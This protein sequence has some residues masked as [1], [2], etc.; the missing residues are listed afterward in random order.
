MDRAT[1]VLNG[2]YLL[3]VISPLFRKMLWLRVTVVLSSVFFVAYGLVAGIVSVA[4]WN[5]V[6][7]LFHL[8]HIGRLVK[9]RRAKS[10]SPKE[11]LIRDSLFRQMD[12]EDFVLFWEMG[13]PERY[14]DAVLCEEGQPQRELIL[15]L[16]G[17]VDITSAA[18]RH[19]AEAGR[20]ELVGEMSF[21]SGQPATADV[22]TRGEMTARVWDQDGLR[23]LE[24]LR[25]EA[26]LSLTRSLGSTVSLKLSGA[27]SGSHGPRQEPQSRT[28]G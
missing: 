16:E 11:Q 9:A 26:A 14:I 2:A 25:P 21:L 10:L 5:G 28:P 1:V 27:E 4:V 8:F 13:R 12:P 15:I 7:G 20:H 6:F 24:R 22:C 3:M 17:H 19:L 23:G 18:G